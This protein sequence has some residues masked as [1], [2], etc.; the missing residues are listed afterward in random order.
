PTAVVSQTLIVETTAAGDTDRVA[1][2]VTLQRD[3]R[4]LLATDK[5]LY[6][7]GQT[8]HLRALAL[9]T[10]DRHP[11]AGQSLDVTIADGKGNKVFHQAVAT[12][13]YGVAAADFPLADQVNTG[14]YKITATLGGTSSET[15]V[16]V[17][18]YVLP[19][20]AVTLTTER[21]Y[22]LPGEHVRGTLVA[23]YFYG[24]P[25]ANSQVRLTGATID[26][27][28]NVVVDLQGTTDADGSYAFA[29][30]LP[31]IL[32]GTDLESGQG[33]FAL[34]ATVTDR[35]Q[36]TEQ[37]SLALP[38]AGSPLVIEAVPE[39]GRLQAGVDNIIYLM[40]SYP[41]GSPAQAQVTLT[42][43][44]QTYTSQAGA[45]GLATIHVTPNVAN[46]SLRIAARDAQGATATRTIEVA[47]VWQD[48]ALQLRPDRAAYHVG[49]TM[50]LTI[51]TAQAGGTVY[52][53]LVRSGQTVS[54]RAI[55]VAGTQ[56]QVAVDVTPALAGTLEL[57]A[58]R[59]R[60]D[61][62]LVRDTRLVIVDAAADLSLT[63]TPDQASYRPGGQA[64][65]DVQV[66]GADG[67][68]APA[69]L[70]LAAVDESVFAL[71][72]QDPGFA[73]LYFQLDQ[74]IL[75]P[76]VE[77]H[78]FQV[79]ELITQPP[80]SDPALRAAQDSAASAALTG[81]G[82]QNVSFTLQA[83][84]RTDALQQASSDQQHYFST[85]ST[86]LYGLVLLLPLAMLGLSGV[87]AWRARRLGRSLRLLLLVAVIALPWLLLGA[88][89]I[90]PLGAWLANP[91]RQD[92]MDPAAM[93]LSALAY[94]LLAL[95]PAL[96]LLLALGSILSLVVL[97]G[98]AWR[99]RDGALGSMLSLGLLY[100]GTVLAL[101]HYLPAASLVPTAAQL[102]WGLLAAG[103]VPLALALRAADLKIAGFPWAALAGGLVAVTLPLG[104]LAMLLI[105]LPIANGIADGRAAPLVGR[106]F[107]P[108]Q[109][110]GA[111]TGLR[112]ADADLRRLQ[113]ALA[114]HAPTAS[115]NGPLPKTY[116]GTIEDQSAAAVPAPPRLRQFFPETMLW[117][118]DAT[119]DAAGHL[120]LDV[121]V[122]DSITTWRL[123]ALAS[124]QD[125]RLGSAT[126]SLRV[127]QDFFVDLTVPP[128]LTVGDEV[129]VPVGVF[130]YL[131]VSQTV[132]LEL[133]QAD[134]LTLRDPPVKE[135]TIGAND[136]GVVYFRLQARD[137]GTHTLK[138]TALGSKLSDAVQRDVRVFPNG[139]Q[140]TF[141]QSDRLS[142][143]APV[144]STVRI[145]A[146]A[147]AGTQAL[148]VKIYPGILSQ[149]V[150]GLDSIL[151]MPSGCFE[152]TSSTTYPN[153]LVLDY[154]KTTNH[155]APATQLK[156]EEYINLGYQRL[157]TFEVAGGGFSLFGTPPADPMLTAYGLQEFGDM[158]RVHPVDPALIQRT[159]AWLL[160]RQQGDGAWE[161]L[162]GFHESALTNQTD[163]L[164]VSAY[165][166]WSLVD[167]GY[168]QEPR[169]AQGLAY[170]RQAAAQTSDPY[171]LA[172]VANAL[173][174]ADVRAG[175][176]PAAGTDAVLERLAGL[177]TH[178][179]DDVLWGSGAG[180]FMGGSGQ[181]GSLETTALAALAFERAGSHAPLA[182]AALTTL[183]RHKDASGTW[184]ST[185]ATVLALKALLQS[186]RGGAEGADATI[187]VTLNGGQQRT[188]QITP[189]TADVVQLL[190]FDGLRIGVDNAVGITAAGRGS[191]LY[192]VAG[193]YYVPWLADQPAQPPPAAEPVTVQ[194]AY[195]RTQ[196]AV[197]DTVGIQV[198]VRLNTPGA[199]DSALIDLGLPPG[200]APE[201]ADLDALIRPPA[202][203]DP[204]GSTPTGIERYE[205]TGR[206]I[207]VYARHLRQGQPLEFRYRLRARF[208]LKAQTPPSQAYDY[209]NP[210]VAG[211]A[212]PQTLEV[213]AP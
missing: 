73:R 28:R 120:H 117:L 135:I 166:V 50:H 1:R 131:P 128:A 92:G 208:P 154:L 63:L 114:A 196:L 52:L 103:L 93:V 119:T 81:A 129:S 79:P 139:R 8:I 42:F 77:L 89:A 145:P 49:E 78:G 39:G 3:Y 4:V 18:H 59:I 112:T 38:V 184:Y 149:V 207:L 212:P 180:T 197:N 65:V 201:T 83:N 125:G 136:I 172:L 33:R 46:Q 98:A 142:A 192:Q 35:A 177:A 140:I 113:G 51:L 7:P 121:P 132:R 199:A 159:A 86:G 102:T 97:V 67:R 11:A 106:D 60:P 122:A 36:Q 123:T 150:E 19:K 10:L 16:T 138:V 61:G 203:P 167:A 58:Y 96:L 14:P 87:A 69:A 76:R 13:A 15:T 175:G 213:T 109:L 95:P 170:L 100:M 204:T 68:G 94:G 152:Q 210:D 124:T 146:A 178:Q 189:Q 168:G 141:S 158:S 23:K 21:P 71:A 44:N 198:T 118:P 37:S 151:R 133:A 173:V 56:A 107:G 185:S 165:V 188:V 55:E 57:H 209:Y 90:A 110:R 194:V 25:V 169:V 137:F 143:Q 191:F 183:L 157:T 24:K 174:A 5:P 164:P 171:V 82:P 116:G 54:T 160:S 193:E 99:R 91:G 9:G 163:R 22:Y 80:A 45:Y 144:S 74:E 64:G 101:V 17:D 30:D 205:L 48:D 105:V 85:L 190:T 127:F 88:N 155:A 6:Q 66:Q 111:P 153:V 115:T 70:G 147:I 126:A 32:T 75:H 179:G 29:F 72:E 20:F 53:D 148:T 130:N 181:A 195:D 62:N 26:V 43:E 211:Q 162:A 108:I 47:G 40:T 206:Q 182:S 84:S 34:E 12:S 104:I 176:G 161:G 2:P 41:D 31:T 27:S 200:F 186:V 187:T 202:A 156:A 134:W